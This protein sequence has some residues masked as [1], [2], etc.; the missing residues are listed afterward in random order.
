[1]FTV[2]GLTG[3]QIWDIL[4]TRYKINIE[5]TTKTTATITVHAHLN[6]VDIDALIFALKDINDQH[7]TI[8]VQESVHNASLG[9]S[10]ALLNEESSSCLDDH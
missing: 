7:A 6:Q 9:A 1:M 4:E 2:Q 3:S 10:G 5:K 8:K